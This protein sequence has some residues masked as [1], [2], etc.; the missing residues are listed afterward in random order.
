[1]HMSW[2]SP[3]CQYGEPTA[4]TI[5]EHQLLIVWAPG[6]GFDATL[7]RTNDLDLLSA[8]VTPYFAHGHCARLKT[9]QLEDSN[10]AS[11]KQDDQTPVVREV[12]HV[13]CLSLDWP[14]SQH[15]RRKPSNG[16]HVSFSRVT[17]RRR[18][19]LCK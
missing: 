3:F 18:P 5:N 12:M 4:P 2:S 11:S 7:D 14:G 9:L 10:V 15:R 6:C 1:M 8:P 19:H 13:Q 16:L 17:L